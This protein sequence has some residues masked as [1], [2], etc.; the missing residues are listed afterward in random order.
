MAWTIAC[1]KLTLVSRTPE[2]RVARLSR[3]ERPDDDLETANRAVENLV[4][5]AEFRDPVYPGLRSTGKVERGG[6]RPY[7]T[8][9]NAENFHAL[10]LLLYTHE[11][12]ID[13]IYIDPP[14]NTGARRLDVQQ[15]LRRRG[16]CLPSLQVAG[17]DGEAG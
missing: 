1:G 11:G 15:R 16:R 7:H 17:H 10:Q 6:D 3:R 14:Y 5:V 13:A 12:K 2:G 8:V 9:L 4:V